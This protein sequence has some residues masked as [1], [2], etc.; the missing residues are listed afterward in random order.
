LEIARIVGTA[1]AYLKGGS[2]ACDAKGVTGEV[3]SRAGIQV[4]R[5]G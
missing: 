2:P 1:K 3:L 4:I 5:V